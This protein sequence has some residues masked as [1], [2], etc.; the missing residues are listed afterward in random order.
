MTD[1]ARPVPVASPSLPGP[2]G[3]LLDLVL[4]CALVLAMLAAY[5]AILGAAFLGVAWMLGAWP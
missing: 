5:A 2:G 3:P 4:P 1:S